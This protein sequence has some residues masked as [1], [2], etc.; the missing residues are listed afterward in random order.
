MK[1]LARRI[2]VSA[3]QVWLLSVIAF[4]FLDLVPGDFYL[5]S[6]MELNASP[7]AMEQWREQH[8]LNLP[9]TT[10][11]GRWASS[12]MRGEFGRSLAYEMPVMVLVRPRVAKTLE[13]VIPALLLCWCFGLGLA[14]VAVKRGGPAVARLEV[15]AVMLSLLPDVIGVSLL[16]WLAVGLKAQSIATAWLP[17]AALTLALLP[18]VLL[19]ATNA[20]S[21]ARRLTFVRLAQQRGIAAGRLWRSYIWPAAANPLISLAG[22]SIAGAIGTS[23]LVEVLL[24]WPGLGPMFLEAAQTRDYPVVTS[25]V[26]LIGTVL[27][28]SN[29]LADLALYR[30]D[31]RIRL[32]S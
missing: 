7:A 4:L 14:I 11:Y 9:W 31:P 3:T 22:L 17:I 15:G 6:A 12:A 27:T 13:I 30:L 19:H 2:A 16:M 26:V 10:R 24:G 28:I 23:L 5:P 18:V 8:G 20:F 29:L 1:Y 25:V 21:G 32:G